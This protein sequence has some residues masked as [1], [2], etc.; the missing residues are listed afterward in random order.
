MNAI[1]KILV[2]AFVTS[3]AVAALAACSGQEFSSELAP[4]KPPDAR[5]TLGWAIRPVDLLLAPLHRLTKYPRRDRGKSWM[6]PSAKTQNLLYISDDGTNDVYVYSWPGGKLLGK[7][8]GFW[9]PQGECVDKKGDVWVVDMGAQQLVEYAHGGTKAI[10]TLRLAGYSPSGCSIDP[11]TGNLAVTNVEGDSEGA[12]GYVEIYKKA[13]GNPTIY[14]DKN[15]ID[16]YF[17]CGY[18]DNGNL[19][20]DGARA[21][22]PFYGFGLIEMPAASGTFTNIALDQIIDYAGAVQW[23][24]KYVAVADTLEHVIYEFTITG[25]NGTETGSTPLDGGSY[26]LQF[27]VQGAIVAG[28]NGGTGNVMFW[29]YPTGGGAIKTLTDFTDP[30]GTVVSLRK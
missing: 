7:L 10:A 14:E 19:Y 17:F 15:D 6:A 4:S 3:I 8:R 13:R 12:D 1:S 5:F 21:F 16:H 26:V 22:P 30:V 28:A 27:W 18:D 23:D 25:S 20:V 24:G 11:T 29:K 2:R 9:Y